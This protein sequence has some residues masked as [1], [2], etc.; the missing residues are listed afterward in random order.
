[1]GGCSDAVALLVLVTTIPRSRRCRYI[2]DNTRGDDLRVLRIYHAGRDPAHRA[3]DRAL[4]AL[5]AEVTLVVPTEWPEGGSE[6]SLSDEP[7]DIVELDVQRAGDVNRHTF[8]DLRALSRLV[9]SLRPDVVD[10]HEE[11]VSLAARQWL[12]VTGK[13][14][15]V[16]YTAQNVDKRYPPPF[17][18]FETAAYRKVRALYPCTRQAA[19]VIRAKGFAGL[20]DVFPLGV[21]D[22]YSPGTQ[23]ADDAEIRLG[24]I[25]R[26]VPEKGIQDAVRLLSTLV[27]HRPARLLVIGQGPEEAVA[28]SLAHRLRVADRVEFLPW[29]PE[30]DLARLY[31]GLHVVLVPSRSTETWVEQFGRIILEGQASGAVIAGYRSGAIPEIADDISVLVPEGDVAGLTEAVR[32]VL[33]DHVRYEALRQKGIARAAEARWPTVAARQLRLYERAVAEPPARVSL[34]QRAHLRRQ[35]AQAEFGPSAE[36]PGGVH[37]PFAVPLLRRDASWTR[38]AGRAID[39]CTRLSGR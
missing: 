9:T 38:V 31:Q 8:A 11:P 23:A 37:R 34:P 28:R 7:F 13:V 17:A 4:A 10:L 12:G 15:V 2:P 32:M 20:I 33:G 22:L 35:F 39:L 25:G 18:Q 3:R 19:A 16:M 5:G 21:S 14:P 27:T 36:L 26:L 6:A 29:Q 30:A 1:M 24:L